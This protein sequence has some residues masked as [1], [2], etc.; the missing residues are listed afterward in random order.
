[1]SILTI[2]LPIRQRARL[3][4]RLK[5]H[6]VVSVTSIAEALES[7]KKDPA[8]LVVYVETEENPEEA[9][10]S[11]L[12]HLQRSRVIFCAK[13]G[14]TA[15]FQ[16]QLV[17]RLRVTAI[18]HHPVDPDELVRRASM[19]LDS[20]VPM[21]EARVAAPSVIPK[22]LLPVWERHQDTNIQRVDILATVM[23]EAEP[24]DEYLEAGRRAAHQLAGSLGTF[25]L[26]AASLLAREAETLITS[27]A[28]LTADQR[29][30]LDKVVHALGLQ[31]AD[32][33]LKLPDLDS[34]APN[35]SL[36]IYSID[37]EWSQEFSDV[38]RIA[39]YLPLLTDDPTGTRR[40]YGLEHPEKV[41]LDLV[42][43]GQDGALL[44]HDLSGQ[45]SIVALVDPQQRNPLLACKT[46]PKNSATADILQALEN[47]EVVENAPT[48]HI[49]AVDDDPIVLETLSAL[50]QALNI[51][52]HT[53]E[54]PL[55]FWET[56]DAV[57][58]E[59]VML[60]VDLPY[61]GG[62]ELCRALRAEPKYAELPVIF[63]S[64]YNDSETVHRVF[65]AGADDYVFKPIIGPELITRTRN[66]LR[67]VRPTTTVPA[68]EASKTT[69][70]RP[71][72]SLL[73]EDDD[74]SREL[75]TQLTQKGLLVNKLSRVES[76]L[77]E[78]LTCEVAERPRV[79]LLDVAVANQ[80]LQGFEGLGINNYCQVWV[81]GDLTDE[82]IVGVFEW[83]LAGYLPQEVAPEVIVRKLQRAALAA[84]A[85]ARM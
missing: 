12:P 30:R 50:L 57:N 21:L 37:A 69:S 15:D 13:Q 6:T 83:G 4:G 38:A 43:I 2:A 77:I 85:Q 41:L 63:L 46:M 42:D 32:P 16:N 78:R 28:T 24:S 8:E 40:V 20:K 54:D 10:A 22:A 51:Q 9:L 72:V 76:Q 58:P 66:R 60:D 81:R 45:G 33:Q 17:K 5:E 23:A 18:L 26:A 74:L 47:A 27:F 82:G 36:L 49:L 61:V 34:E 11:L 19:E 79:V 52:V 44:V 73:L 14:H 55:K 7:L 25:G 53:L 80:V 56:L 67:R 48:R 31:I 64:A 75:F 62:V 59:I 84:G 3:V 68:P 29:K 35:G 39:G 1:V 71:D 70:G 65:S